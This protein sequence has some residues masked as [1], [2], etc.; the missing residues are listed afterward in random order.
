VIILSRLSAP[1]RRAAPPEGGAGAGPLRPCLRTAR[2]T[3]CPNFWLPGIRTTP[4]RARSLR[5]LPC[6]GECHVHRR[7]GG[8]GGCV[9]LLEREP[10]L[11]MHPIAAKALAWCATAESF[12]AAGLKRNLPRASP[13]LTMRRLV[14]FSNLAHRFSALNNSV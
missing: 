10:D 11:Y 5:H 9:V 14:R 2:V 7:T 13:S 1:S 8:G 6:R 12:P 3:L 4:G